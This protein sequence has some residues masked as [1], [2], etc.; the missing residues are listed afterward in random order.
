MLQNG[1]ARVYAV[2]VGY[3]QLDWKLRNDERVVC[4]ERTNARFLTHKAD[5]GGSW[6]SRPSM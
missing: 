1:A 3:A 4:M 6:I 2:D 5:P